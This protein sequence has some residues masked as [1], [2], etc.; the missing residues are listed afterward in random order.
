MEKFRDE[1]ETIGTIG[2]VE[3]DYATTDKAMSKFVKELTKLSKKTGISIETT[4][5]LY[6]DDPKNIKSI[7]YS[8]DFS[9]GDLS[10]DLKTWMSDD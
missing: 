4:G 6:Y 10:C 7:S 1:L 2:M 9:S 8:E 3:A 5:G